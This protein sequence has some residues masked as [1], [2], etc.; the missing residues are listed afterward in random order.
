M[1]GGFM[2]VGTPDRDQGKGDGAQG[3]LLPQS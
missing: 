3:A 1:I 2:G